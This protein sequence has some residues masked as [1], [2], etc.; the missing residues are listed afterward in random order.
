MKGESNYKSC[1]VATDNVSEGIVIQLGESSDESA[2][3]EADTV[4]PRVGLFAS[5]CQTIK[6]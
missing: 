2:I 1:D 4:V 6:R 5:I 3:D